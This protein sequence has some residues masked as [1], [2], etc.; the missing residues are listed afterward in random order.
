MID[1][2]KMKG[3]L[4]TIVQEEKS[5]KV[6]MLAYSS[7]ESLENALRERRGV[8]YSRSRKRLWVKGESSG[9]SQKLKKAFADCDSDALL[10]I[11]KQKGSACHT[12]KK[13]CFFKEIDLKQSRLESKG[14]E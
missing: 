3:L 10:F 1:W 9:N 13:S 5:G 4:P 2:K 6:L 12:G 7:K 8:Y 14:A 11:V